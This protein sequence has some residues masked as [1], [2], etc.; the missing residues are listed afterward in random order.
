MSHFYISNFILGLVNGAMIEFY[1]FADIYLTV[2]LGDA[3]NNIIR[4]S[5]YMFIKLLHDVNVNIFIFK[6]SFSVMTIEPIEF[7]YN[8]RDDKYVK[9]VQVSFTL[10]YVIIDY[11]CQNLPS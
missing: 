3:E 1:E 4:F 5:A 6:L 11:K 8:E 7:R 2:Q 9:L 10:A